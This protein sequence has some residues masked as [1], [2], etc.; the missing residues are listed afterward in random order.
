MPSFSLAVDA[1]MEDFHRRPVSARST[2]EKTQCGRDARVH[3][4]LYLE[5]ESGESR[6]LGSTARRVGSR[7][8]GGRRPFHQRLQKFVHPEI[9]DARAEENR[10][11][12][13]GEKRMP[14]RRARWRFVSAQRRG[15]MPPSRRETARRARIRRDRRINSPS[16]RMRSSP[17]VNQHQAIASQIEDSL[18]TLAHADRPGDRRAVDLEDRLDFLEQ[19]HRLARLAIHLVHKR[20]DRRVAQAAH[21]ERLIVCASTPLAASMTI[22]A[23]STAVRTR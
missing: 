11:L 13:A 17:G 5:D 20:D 8:C 7:G 1:Q 22:T 14:G 21:L 16:S 6:F 19:C 10:R 9:V 12:T 23:A 15:A 3:V 2:R 4:R 18:E